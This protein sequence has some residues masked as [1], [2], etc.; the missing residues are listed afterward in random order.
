MICPGP[1]DF[2]ANSPVLPKEQA[3]NS[4]SYAGINGKVGPECTGKA[5]IQRPPQD[6]NAGYPRVSPEWQEDALRT[7]SFRRLKEQKIV[8]EYFGLVNCFRSPYS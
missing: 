5:P 2:K 1:R 7:G 3:R 6:S 8:V 4:T